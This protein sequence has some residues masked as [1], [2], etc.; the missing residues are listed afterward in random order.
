MKVI[1]TNRGCL[2]LTINQLHLLSIAN[3]S[4]S[5]TFNFRDEIFFCFGSTSERDD[6]RGCLPS[7]FFTSG[8]S[9]AS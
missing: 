1:G 8:S 6:T 2:F 3:D 9:I 4:T 7:I 5:F